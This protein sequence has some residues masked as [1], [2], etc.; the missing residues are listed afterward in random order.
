MTILDPRLHAF[1]ADLADAPA[2]RRRS[3]PRDFADGDLLQIVDPIAS[4]RR[5][6]RFDAVQTTQA[7]LGETVRV[8]ERREGWA[9]VQLERDGYVGYAAEDDLCGVRVGAPTHRVA[10]PS[11]F[12]SR[13]RHQVA[14]GRTSADE[15]GGDRDWQSARNF[16]ELADGRLSIARP[17]Q[18]AWRCR[19]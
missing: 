13:P 11:T 9:W 7:L 16:A 15:R 2:A 3:R 18:A 14:A 10:V 12:L 8:F 6:P 5:E 17:S 19:A 1:R 4:I